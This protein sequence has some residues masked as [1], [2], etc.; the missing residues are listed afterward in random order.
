DGE[1]CSICLDPWTSKGK[2]RICTLL[3]GHLF[4]QSC[5]ERWLKERRSCP[6]CGAKVGTKGSNRIIPLYLQNLVA[7]DTGELETARSLL[8]EEKRLR[9]Q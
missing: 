6:Q 3:C 4:G 2:H 5:I 1:R 9:K 8:E 7:K